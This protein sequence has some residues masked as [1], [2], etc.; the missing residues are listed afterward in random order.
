M[1]ASTGDK[2]VAKIAST[3]DK[4]AATAASTADEVLAAVASAMNVAAAEDTADE[5]GVRTLA[6]D[7]LEGP[8]GLLAFQPIHRS[9]GVSRSADRSRVPSAP[10]ASHV[11]SLC[12]RLA[13]GGRSFFRP[14]T[15]AV[16]AGGAAWGRRMAMGDRPFRDFGVPDPCPLM[17]GFRRPPASFVCRQP[18]RPR[19]AVDESGLGQCIPSIS[20]DSL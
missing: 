7:L 11:M 1:V 4:A 16:D 17:E 10:N 20:I 8:P 3:A 5:S 19:S 6:P 9:M 13:G 14:P 18:A 2:V 12:D 15:T